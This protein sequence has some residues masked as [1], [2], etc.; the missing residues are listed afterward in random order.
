M[1]EGRTL[2]YK[3]GYEKI[4][5][6]VGRYCDKHRLEEVCLIEFEKGIILQGLQVES[7][8]DGYTRRL[9]S[10]TWAYEQL[11]NMAH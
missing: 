5:R 3:L 9:I 11:A 4:L 1:D 6:A 7:T 8:S 2:K 10:E